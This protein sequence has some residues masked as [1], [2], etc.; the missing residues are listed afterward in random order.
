MK[1]LLLLFMIFPLAAATLIGG[2][3][4]PKYEDR[5]EIPE[6]YKWDLTVMYETWDDWE[7][8]V[9]QFKAIYEN[10]AEM[11]GTLGDNPKNLVNFLSMQDKA[12]EVGI[13]VYCYAYLYR[14]VDTRNSEANSRFQQ[15]AGLMSQL[16]TKMSWVTPELLDIPEDTMKKWIESTPELE[17]F[18]FGLTKMYRNQEY[19]LDAD[20][21]RLLS[22]FSNLRSAPGNVYTEL[23]TSDIQREEV[24]LSDGETLKMTPGNYSQVLSFNRNRDDREAAFHAFFAPYKEYENTYAAILN[25]VHQGDWASVRARGHETFLDAS[26][27]SNDIPKDV[28]FNLINTAKNNTDAVQK[29]IDIRRRAL[30]YDEYQQWDGSISITDFE[31]QYSW[32]EASD[33]VYN[34]IAPLGSDYQKEIG[35]CFSGG[36]IDVYETPGKESGAYNM[37]VYGVH[38]FVLMNYSGTLRNVF[39]LGHELGHSLHSIYSSR[40]QPYNIHR[41]STFVAEVASVFNEHLLLDYMLKQSKNPKERIALLDQAINNIL[42]TFY[43]QSLFADF[44]YQVRTLVEEGKPINAPALNGIMGDLNKAYYGDAM[45]HNE[46]S[47]V[48]WAYVMHFFQLKYYVFQYAT[49]YAASAHLFDKVTTGSKRE[50][51]V[52]TE[53]YIDLLKSGG[54]DYP[55]NQL[56]AAGVDMT[57]PEVIVSV[58]RRLETLVDQLEKELKKIDAL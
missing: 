18:K 30:G 31:K 29:Y 20:K 21:E 19:V 25:A 50:R 13:K 27:F 46:L 14:S 23:S 53:K 58:A 15:I 4:I 57:D 7:K 36:R 6:K 1:K 24:T 56:K 10:M 8:D 32:D 11:Q 52:A 34:A 33:L 40:N 49:S 42:G 17:P 22:Y 47:S 35:K 55:I 3:Q 16:G 12:G 41:Y 51:K 39:T 37:G 44:E 2:N 26:L 28:Y 5:D 9:E 48:T 45:V 54:S 38:P 43:R